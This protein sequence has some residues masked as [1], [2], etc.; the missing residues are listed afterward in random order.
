MPSATVVLVLSPPV[1]LPSTGGSF[2]GASSNPTPA[3]AGNGSAKLGSA[4]NGSTSLGG[5]ESPIVPA[6]MRSSPREAR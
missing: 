1:S 3:A 6:P 2:T 4:A 5:K